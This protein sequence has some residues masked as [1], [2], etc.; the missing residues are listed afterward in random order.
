ML[1]MTIYAA[2]W[3]FGKRF[4]HGGLEPSF[5]Q[6]LAVQNKFVAPKLFAGQ[7]NLRIPSQP[8]EAV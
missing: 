5:A 6:I 1:L 7:K 8:V 2:S 3:N 4:G